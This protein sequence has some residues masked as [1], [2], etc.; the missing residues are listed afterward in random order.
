MV[1]PSSSST[2]SPRAACPR[3]CPGPLRPTRPRV[4]APVRGRAGPAST[5]GAPRRS[6]RRAVI[7]GREACAPDKSVITRVPRSNLVR[8]VRKM[9]FMPPD[10]PKRTAFLSGST[11]NRHNDDRN[12]RLLWLFPLYV[13]NFFEW[14][15]RHRRQQRPWPEWR[16]PLVLR[17]LSRCLW[18]A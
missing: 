17:R 9:T 5:G 10:W 4:S 11:C 6:S 16:T 13:Y 18:Q 2:T 12:A 14:R 3:V 7:R 15:E 1:A 8:Q